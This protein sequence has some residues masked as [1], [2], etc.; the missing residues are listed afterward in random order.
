MEKS[1]TRTVRISISEGCLAYSYCINDV[2][3]VDLTD[4]DSDKYDSSLVNAVCSELLDELEDQYPGIPSFL[5][6]N[7][8]EV[9]NHNSDLDF[10]QDVFIELVKNNK[11]T[12]HAYLGTCDECGDTI[13]TYEL[14]IE[15][16]NYNLD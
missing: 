14:T 10:E 5:I 6:Y 9:G 7:L 11:N 2:E 15:V 12:N 16:P 3:W 13:E 4:K 1:D 8:Y